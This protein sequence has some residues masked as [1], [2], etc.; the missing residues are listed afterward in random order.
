M[1][2]HGHVE[3]GNGITNNVNVSIDKSIIIYQ[4]KGYSSLLDL[5]HLFNSW[6]N[7]CYAFQ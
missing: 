4:D 7:N 6:M 2:E 1:L 3:V 5:Y